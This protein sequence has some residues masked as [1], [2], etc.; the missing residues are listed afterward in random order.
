MPLYLSGFVFG[1]MIVYNLPV[2]KRFIPGIALTGFLLMW[3]GRLMFHA[4]FEEDYHNAP[5]VIV[6]GVGAMMLVWAIAAQPEAFALLRHRF[7][8]W[9]GDISYSLYLVHLSILGLITGFGTERLGLAF[10][11][12]S[13]EVA[14]I[15]AMAAT[16]AVTL[17]ISDLIYRY[18]ELP[19]IA[20]GK[21]V[22]KM[23]ERRIDVNLKLLRT[24]D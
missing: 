15:V 17:L 20:M 16:L 9:L 14:T 21:T 18:I 3:F 12:R 11:T 2:L 23:I 1:A 6:E 5:S 24:V 4:G 19:M 7:L 10:M 8:I 22:A 13:G